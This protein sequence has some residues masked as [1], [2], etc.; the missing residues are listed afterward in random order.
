MFA[1]DVLISDFAMIDLETILSEAKEVMEGCIKR[2]KECDKRSEEIGNF[3]GYWKSVYNIVKEKFGNKKAKK[4]QKEMLIH[5]YNLTK[6]EGFEARLKY[7]IGF[8][9]CER[10]YKEIIQKSCKE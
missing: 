9:I 4:F 2:I 6:D 5:Y 3:D 10:R 8:N 7:S 1:T